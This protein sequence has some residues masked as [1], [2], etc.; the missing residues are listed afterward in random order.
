[1]ESKSRHI[2]EDNKSRAGFVKNWLGEKNKPGE[3]KRSRETIEMRKDERLVNA[4]K[5]LEGLDKT[6]DSPK[7]SG[8]L[9]RSSRLQCDFRLHLSPF[10]SPRVSFFP[11]NRLRRWSVDLRGLRLARREA[12]RRLHI[13]QRY[14][15]RA[16]KLYQAVCYRRFHFKRDVT[17]NC[18]TSERGGS[19]VV[20]GGVLR[21]DACRSMKPGEKFRQARGITR[22]LSRGSPNA[23][24]ERERRRVREG[25]G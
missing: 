9:Q 5:A 22:D 21:Y 1:M 8:T 7:S 13:V 18:I 19:R 6:K 14:L 23:T 10:R 20:L 11:R 24:R 25:G 12:N 3:R 4:E 15:T 16:C 2:A 17:R